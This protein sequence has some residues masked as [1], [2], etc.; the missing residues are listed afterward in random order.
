MDV[1]KNPHAEGNMEDMI[2][3]FRHKDGDHIKIW[4]DLGSNYVEI[5][6]STDAA[7]RL[8]KTIINATEKD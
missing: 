2:K 3:I 8:G 1:I 7:R 6:L 4:F 5:A